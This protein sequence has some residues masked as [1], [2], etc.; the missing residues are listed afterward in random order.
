MSK[1]IGNYKGMMSTTVFL[2]ND[3]SIN[4]S[5]RNPQM[6]SRRL[7][8]NLLKLWSRSVASKAED[9]PQRYGMT[10]VMHKHEIER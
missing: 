1:K 5:Y 10:T 7:S 8:H 2:L 6:L 4:S 3:K 9:P